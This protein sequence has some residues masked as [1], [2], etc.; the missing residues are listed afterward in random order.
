MSKYRT[1]TV[2]EIEYKWCITSLGF[3]VKNLPP[4]PFDWI[5]VNVGAEMKDFERKRV[6]I[7]PRHVRKWIDENAKTN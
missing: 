2:D 3:F 4:P 5:R 6:A 7:T 1:I